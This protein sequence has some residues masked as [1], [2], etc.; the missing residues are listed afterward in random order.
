MFVLFKIIYKTTFNY[1]FNLKSWLL[2]QNIGIKFK[3]HNRNK[4][5]LRFFLKEERG[6]YIS[7]NDKKSTQEY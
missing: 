4:Y 5:L 7:K 6:G 1:Q 2:D 3:Y